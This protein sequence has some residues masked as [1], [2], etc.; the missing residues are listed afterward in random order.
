MR[1]KYL[2]ILLFAGLPLI[3]QGQDSLYRKEVKKSSV[4]A[5][6]KLLKSFEESKPDTE[7]AGNYMTLAAELAGQKEYAKAEENLTKAIN[8]YAK[9]KEKEALAASYRELAK[10]QEAQGKIEKAIANYNKAAGV[11]GNKVTKDLNT[12]DANRLKNRE[13]LEAQSEYI[14][15]NIAISNQSSNK[16]EA[17]T[18]YRQMAQ[19]KLEMDDKEGA[20]GEY[21]N[22]LMNVKDKPEE[23]IKIQQEI[24]DTYIAG[25]EYEKAIAINESLVSEARKTKDSKTEIEQLKNL[26]NTYLEANKQ[27]KAISSLEE[28]YEIAVSSG[29]TMEA[30]DALKLLAEQYNKEKKTN[31]ALSAYNDFLNKLDTLIKADSSL[32]DTR[33]FQSHEEKISQLEK[34]RTLKDELIARKNRFNSVLLICIGLILVSLLFIVRTLYSI[35]RKNKK[36]ALQSLRREM[37]PHFIF[38][39]LNSVNQFIAQNNE[40]EANK[41]LSSYSKLMRNIMENSNRDFISLSTELEQLKEYL[42][43]EHMRFRDKFAYRITVDEALDAD[44]TYI[45]N[46][47]IQ[48]QLENAIW[49]GLRYKEGAGTLALTIHK[50]KESVIVQV[51]DDGIGLQ[52]SRELKTKHQKRHN[53]RGLTN[54]GERIRLLNELYGMRIVMEVTDKEGKETGVIVRLYFPLINKKPQT[55]EHLTEDKE[56]NR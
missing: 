44:A 29:H 7:V 52:K 37:N 4:K 17:A 13:S 45:P 43:L 51:E 26:S 32:V 47:L 42:D 30:R 34:E 5:S 14:Q 55:D 49:H 12:N 50:E 27:D 24:A 8:I 36:I 23:A 6:S 3:C 38:N 40:L 25:E 54:T 19:V 2:F 10:V 16:E 35:R 48:P 18:A 28:A 41:Y 56:R 33:I 20:I 39:S 53:S 1:A 15:K 11:S 22:A 9:G 21:Q 46:M 31:R